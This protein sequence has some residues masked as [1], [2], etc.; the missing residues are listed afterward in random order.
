VTAYDPLA[1]ER[2]Q[3]QPLVVYIDNR[4]RND[5]EHGLPHAN[6]RGHECS[7][8]NDSDRC[9]NEHYLNPSMAPGKSSIDEHFLRPK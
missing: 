9:P 3:I 7:S 4:V 5:A 8:D 2:A 6:D 1:D